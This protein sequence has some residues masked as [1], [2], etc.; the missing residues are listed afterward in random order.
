MRPWVTDLRAD[1]LEPERRP[2]APK[3]SDELVMTVLGHL[4]PAA[5]RPGPVAWI[6]TRD[7]LRIGRRLARLEDA[8]LVAEIR[9][10]APLL[11][12]NGLR[13]RALRTAAAGIRELTYRHLG[14]RHHPVQV[15]GGLAL[16]RGRIVEM[17]TGEGKTITTLIPALVVALT[18]VPVHVITVNPYLAARDAATLAP[19]IEA[20]GL[21]HL[22]LIH[23]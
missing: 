6:E 21:S 5:R 15:T 23:I 7:T 16:A 2:R 18:G 17:A 11:L 8:A 19:V 12:A 4:R 14:M 9:A 20:L 13:G 3:R 10:Q 22:S 1:T